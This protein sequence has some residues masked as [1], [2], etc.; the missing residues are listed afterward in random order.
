[1][2]LLDGNDSFEVAGPGSPMGLLP[3]NTYVLGR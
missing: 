2:H 1:M 3:L